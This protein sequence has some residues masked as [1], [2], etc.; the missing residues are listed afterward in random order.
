[1]KKVNLTFSKGVSEIQKQTIEFGLNEGHDGMSAYQIAV[2]EGFEGSQEEWLK[3]LQGPAGKSAYE[4][5]RSAGGM[6]SEVQFNEVL[7]QAPYMVNE[8]KLN[9]EV[10][11]A[12]NAEQALNTSLQGKVTA[13]GGEVGNTVAAFSDAETRANIVSGEKLTTLFGKIRKWFA[14]LKTVAFS[15]KYSDLSGIPTALP[16]NGGAA[17]SAQKDGAGNVITSTYLSKTNTVEYKPASDYNPA[18]KQY[19]DEVQVSEINLIDGSESVVIEAGTS[20]NKVK[21]FSLPNRVNAGEQYAISIDNITNLTG[22]PEG[23]MIALYS[24][25]GTK[26]LANVLTFT[27]KNRKGVFTVLDTVLDENASLFIYAGISTATA[28]NTIQYDGVM[29]VHGKHPALCWSPKPIA[30]IDIPIAV[31]DLQTSSSSSEVSTAVG[32]ADYFMEI[33]NAIVNK[34]NIRITGTSSGMTYVQYPMFSFATKEGG[35]YKIVVCTMKRSTGAPDQRVVT[36]LYNETSETFS[37]QSVGSAI[38]WN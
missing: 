3:S 9:Q 33:Y 24:P 13:Q 18:T 12:T 21:T 23:Y 28:G 15:G 14:D 34:Q 22:N 8:E 7:T 25:D 16:A 2:A 10:L 1:M 19:V 17:E 5:Y 29:L 27:Q 37:C 32:G 31:T 38:A 26:R 30:T 11:R 35:N 36:I 20:T 6:L 4:A